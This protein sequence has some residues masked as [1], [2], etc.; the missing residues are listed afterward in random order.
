MEVN[1][2][3]AYRTSYFGHGLSKDDEIFTNLHFGWL[4]VVSLWSNL[5]FG[6]CPPKCNLSPYIV[7]VG[8]MSSTS[9]WG[10]E[11]YLGLNGLFVKK[12]FARGIPRKPIAV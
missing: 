9:Q 11:E 3:S 7:A 8:G 12:S 5:T 4:L 1:S 6:I 10:M 2:L